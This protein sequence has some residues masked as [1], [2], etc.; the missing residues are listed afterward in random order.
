M[1]STH[2]IDLSQVS[3][4]HDGRRVLGPFSLRLTEPRIGIVGRN[5]SGKST[6]LRLIAGLVTPDGGRVRVAGADV[7]RDRAAAL[8]AVGILFQNPDHQIIFP[9]VIEEIAFGLT[10]LGAPRTDARRRAAEVLEAQGRA[11]WADRST[12]ALSQGQR[13]FLCLMAVLA[14]APRTIVLDEPFTGLDIPTR[15]QLGR[16]IA[17][18]SQQVVMVTHDVSL[19]EGFDRVL[20]LDG[21]EV[22]ADGPAATVLAGFSAAMQAEGARDPCWP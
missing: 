20:W 11:G 2:G 4:A 14:M 5:G 22:R 1:H 12:H 19:L 6:L 21:G 18:L 10:Q 17:G 3:V 9:T 13:Q 16:A 15:L 7:V 8:R